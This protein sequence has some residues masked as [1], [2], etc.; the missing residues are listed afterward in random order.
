MGNRGI[1]VTKNEQYRHSVLSDFIGGKLKRTEVSRLLGTTERNVTRMASRIRKRGIEGIKHGN[2]GRLSTNRCDVEVKAQV[3]GLMKERYYDLNLTHA[4]EKLL[5]EH[6]LTVGRETFRKW[7]HGSGLVKRRHKR[8]SYARIYR[9]RMP[10]AGMLLQMDGSP[11][12][13]NGEDTWTLISAIDDATSDI[14][15]AE[16]YPSE[17]TEN[18]MRLLWRIIERCGLPEALYVDR[19]GIF[20]GPKRNQFSQ[21]A[22]ACE[23]LGIRIIFAYSPQAKGRIERSFQT[24]QDRLVPELRLRNIHRMA[25]AND[26][27]HNEYLPNFWRQ[28]YV[29]PAREPMSRYRSL[30]MTAA[31]KEILCW[32]QWRAIASDQTISLENKRLLVDVPTR[33]SIRGQ[34]VDVRDYLDG[35][36]KA[37]FAGKPVE[38][39]QL[40][41][42]LALERLRRKA[43]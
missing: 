25:R 18:C 7:C 13:W 4:R 38:L 10:H 37:Y 16:F 42:A 9:Q 2:V 35:S 24:L 8:R 39:L 5:S 43:G 23:E 26:F 30:P 15:W 12:R 19:A 34:K 20:G 32:K 1:F 27:L 11:H 29:I 28:R 41:D 31:L 14:A 17:D 40:D 22:R 33:Y 21:L 6:N 36:R 3:M